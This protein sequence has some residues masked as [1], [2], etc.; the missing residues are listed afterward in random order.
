MQTSTGT[1]YI[2]STPIGNLEDLTLR[3]LRILKEVDLI[4][5]E[6]TRHTRKLLSAYEIHTSLTSYFDHN[7]SQKSGVL[8]QKLFNG[9]SVA[10]VS[11]AGTPG[12][13]DPGYDVIR[14]AIAENIPVVPIPGPSAILAALT[15]SGLPMDRFVFIGFLTNKRSA[16]IKQLKEVQQEQKTI[17]CYVSPHHFLKALADI[18]QI[19]GNRRITATRE[20]T[21]KFEELVRGDV[22]EILEHFSQKP[23]IKGEFTLVVAGAAT[24]ARKTMDSKAIA[25]ELEKRIYEQELSRKDAVK[26]VAATFGLPKNTVYQVSLELL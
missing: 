9:Q 6:D 20:L 12:I 24:A 5:A 14:A 1:L 16:R 22:D 25:I 7:E 17:V 3:A 23:S 2:V 10:L 15:V 18:R 13:S 8:L 11:D 26:Q 21:K 19:L 4:A